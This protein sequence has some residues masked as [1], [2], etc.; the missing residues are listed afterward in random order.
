M[1]DPCDGHLRQVWC[2]F[3]GQPLLSSD[4]HLPSVII[5]VSHAGSSFRLLAFR[6]V[7][8]SE[9]SISEDLVLNWLATVVGASGFLADVRSS[10]FHCK[11]MLRT[12][13]NASIFCA[14]T[15]ASSQKHHS[16]CF[17]L[18]LVTFKCLTSVLRGALNVAAQKI[19]ADGKI[20]CPMLR[21]GC[22]P[23]PT[24]WQKFEACQGL[25]LLRWPTLNTLS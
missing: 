16:A 14:L 10:N 3:C 19:V 23:A 5:S 7:R 1:C 6:K 21:C 13:N 15:T 18:F 11:K 9:I 17:S 24:N 12:Q 20:N 4:H 8:D 22:S 25:S 2:T